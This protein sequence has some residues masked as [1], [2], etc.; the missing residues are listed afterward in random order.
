MDKK[1]K[2]YRS[3]DVRYELDGKTLSELAEFFR[4]AIEDYP[5]DSNAYLD[6][7]TEDDYSGTYA[8]V[9]IKWVEEET[10]EEF[11][12]RLTFNQT[13]QEQRRKLFKQLQAEFEGDK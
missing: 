11:K 5:P 6:I 10:D 13:V 8:R 12:A 1:I 3:K 7:G 9:E 2:L 4:K